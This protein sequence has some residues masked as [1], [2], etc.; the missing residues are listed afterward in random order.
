MLGPDLAIWSLPLGAAQGPEHQGREHHQQPA[1]G[2]C[3]EPGGAA[4]LCL[5]AE[6]F[7]NPVG[8]PAHE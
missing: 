4:D 3:I 2:R 5:D 1:G 8:V 7:V 6:A